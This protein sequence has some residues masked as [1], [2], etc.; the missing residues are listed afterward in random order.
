VVVFAVGIPLKH[1]G[2]VEGDVGVSRRF[3]GSRK[4]EH[5]VILKVVSTNICGSDQKQLAKAMQS[6]MRN[7]EEGRQ[8]ARSA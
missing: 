4:R 1:G 2:K 8:P 3:L 7:G 6:R 5:G